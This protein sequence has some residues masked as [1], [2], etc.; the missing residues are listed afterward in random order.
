MTDRSD[1][2]ERA[3]ERHLGGCLCG[4]VR[5]R[6]SGAVTPPAA[7]HCDMCRRHH[8]APGTFVGARRAA[9]EI[10]GEAEILWLASSPQLE[11]GSC[12]RCGSKLFVRSPE[13]DELDITIGSLDRSDDVAVVKHIWVAHRGDYEEL[14]ADVPAFARSSMR[15]GQPVEPLNELPPLPTAAPG[16]LSGRCFCGKVTFEMTE[17]PQDVVVCHCA[18]CRRW[19]GDAGASCA[20]PV[21]ALTL[22]GQENLVWYMAST[23]TLRGFCRHCASCLFW[24]RL[25]AGAPAVEMAVSA[26]ALDGPTGLKTV[27]QIFLTD[28]IA[29][30]RPGDAASRAALNWS[31]ATPF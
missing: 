27:R 15:D 30:D 4:A 2:G 11:R 31:S 18:Q 14:P 3:A 5:Y 7:C 24:Q 25:Q 9:V 19:H 6:V 28:R 29:P 8:G 12:R 26:G 22:R 10:T 23:E 1:H 21:S 20:I 16:A 17:R 13:G